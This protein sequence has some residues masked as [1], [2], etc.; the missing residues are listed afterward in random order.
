MNSKDFQKRFEEAYKLLT[1]E[2]TNREKF[3]S[4]RVL[5]KGYNPKI[6]SALAKVSNVLSDV[7]KL[8]KR[9]YIELGAENLPENTED[10]KKRKKAIV[11]FIRYWKE[12]ASEVERVRNGFLEKEN[13]D[14]KNSIEQIESSAKIL[15]FAKGPFGIITIAAVAIVAIFGFINSQKAPAKQET[16]TV[17]QVSA[18]QKIQVIV[19][20]DKRIPLSQVHF[21]TGPECEGKPHYHANANNMAKATDGTNVSDPG[22]CGFG[23]VEEIKIEEVEQP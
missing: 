3:E 7:E 2:T 9:E 15:K 11:A 13:G 5:I 19:V 12:L 21:A 23:K 16:D 22:G 17:N 18:K 14:S 6:D 4:I 1:Q 20:N 10:E 8:Q